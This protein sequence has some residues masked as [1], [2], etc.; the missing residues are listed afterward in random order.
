M[1]YME[2][3]TVFSSPLAKLILHFTEKRGIC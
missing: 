2:D 3:S 1:A